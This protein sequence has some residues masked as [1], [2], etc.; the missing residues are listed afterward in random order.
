MYWR[1]LRGVSRAHYG[2]ACVELLNGGSIPSVKEHFLHAREIIDGLSSRYPDAVPLRWELSRFAFLST[3][4]NDQ[5]RSAWIEAFDC[6]KFHLVL[7]PPIG[8]K[9]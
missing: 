3:L 4:E 1:S 2:L 5:P 7:A 9:N 8:Y 6:Y